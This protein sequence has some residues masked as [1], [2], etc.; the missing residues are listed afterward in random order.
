MENQ[1]NFSPVAVVIWLAVAIPLYAVMIWAYVRIIQK[2]GYSGWNV[3]WGLVPIVNIIMFF[4]FAF[5]D[6]PVTKRMR[7]LEH[8]VFGPGSSGAIDRPA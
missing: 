7:E 5:G 6:W 1:N 3:L 4:V 2:A 8:Q